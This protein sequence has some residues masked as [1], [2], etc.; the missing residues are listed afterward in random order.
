MTANEF[1]NR[2]SW[3]LESLSEAQILEINEKAIPINTK[4]VT[5]VGLGVFQSKVM[6][7]NIIL[8]LNFTKEAET[9][10]LTRNTCQLPSLFTNVEIGHKNT[11]IV[12]FTSLI[13][14]LVYANVLFTSVSVKS[15]IYS[16]RR[17]CD[18]VNILVYHLHFGG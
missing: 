18:S 9:V 16:T 10:T 6:F 11:K 14:W 4:K 3:F 17:I 7:L 15:P 12:I 5:K 1:H 2:A 8:R 13:H